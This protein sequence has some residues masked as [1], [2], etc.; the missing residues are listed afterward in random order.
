MSHYFHLLISLILLF[1]LSTLTVAKSSTQLSFDPPKI[2]SSGTAGYAINFRSSK[3]PGYATIARSKT[4]ED[5]FSR[6]LREL[7]VSMWIKTSFVTSG[8]QTTTL[9]DN[10][11]S[12]KQFRLSLIHSE[13]KNTTDV[14]FRLGSRTGTVWDVIWSPNVSVDSLTWTHLAISWRNGTLSMYKDGVLAAEH[15]TPKPLE[16]YPG[17]TDLLVAASPTEQYVATGEVTQPYIGAIDDIQIWHVGQSR[18]N[19]EG[20]RAY[21]RYPNN[22]AI[23]I[24]GYWH[25]D[26]GKGLR[27]VNNIDG[28]YSHLVL[29]PHSVL[30]S[31]AAAAMEAATATA[32]ASSSLQWIVSQA[33]VGDQIEQLEDMDTLIVLN[34][35]DNKVGRDLE[36]IITV[37]PTKGTLWEYNISSITNNGS[38]SIRGTQIKQVPHLLLPTSISKSKVVYAPAINS[39]SSVLDKYGKAANTYTQFS[40]RVKTASTESLSTSLYSSIQSVIRIFVDPVDDLPQFVHPPTVALQFAD[41]GIEDPDA[42]EREGGE[43]MGVTLSITDTKD[44]DVLVPHYSK[45]I[46]AEAAAAAAAV[47]VLP[48]SFSSDSRISLGSTDAL[49]F[50]GPLGY[51]DGKN[52]VGSSKFSGSLSNVNHAIN[53]FTLI[54]PTLFGGTVSLEVEDQGAQGRGG[55]LATAHQVGVQL[56]S[57]SIPVISEMYPV[58][59]P[60]LG[61]N[62]VLLK[63][64]NF[65]L[66]GSHVCVFGTTRANATLLPSSQLKCP[67]PPSVGGR[68]GL[69]SLLVINEAGFSSNTLQFLYE[70]SPTLIRIKPDAGPI[71]GG[72]VVLLLGEGFIH[73]KHLTCKIGEQHV[74]AQFVSNRIIKCVTPSSLIGSTAINVA[75]ANNGV[76]FGS[77]AQFTYS[78]PMSV[79][80]VS[81]QRGPSDGHT[82]VNVQ[83]IHFQNSSLLTCRFGTNVVLAIYKSPTSIHCVVPSAKSH[84]S[85]PLP[86]AVLVGVANNGYDFMDSSIVTYTYVSPIS[87]SHI[88]P[89]TGPVEG[90]TAIFIYG[91]NFLS[92]SKLQ[93]RFGS[94]TVDGGQMVPSTFFSTRM[95]RCIAPIHAR[96][97]VVVEITTNNVDFTNNDVEF[98]YQVQAAVTSISPSFGPITGGTRV[99]LTGT[100]FPRTN[101]LQCRFGERGILVPAIW[102]APTVVECIVPMVTTVQSVLVQLT[103]NTVDFTTPSDDILFSYIPPVR[104]LDIS[105]SQGP[106]RGG[107]VVTVRGSG[108]VSN[109]PTISQLYKCSFGLNIVRAI[110]IN[111]T[112]IRCTVPSISSSDLSVTVKVSTNGVQ[113]TDENM[114]F[115]Y[116]NSIQLTNIAP[117]A[118]PESGGT[119]ITVHGSGFLDST[120]L[121]CLFNSNVRVHATFI[122]SQKISCISPPAT[123]TTKRFGVT[124]TV[125]NNG[126]DIS[127]AGALQYLYHGRPTVSSISPAYGLCNQ[128]NSTTVLTVHGS[129]F[130][131]TEELSCRVG[132]VQAVK[133]QF[134]SSTVLFCTIQFL[135]AGSHQVLVSNNKVDYSTSIIASNDADDKDETQF[136]SI[137]SFSIVSM[138]PTNGSLT[139]GTDIFFRLNA[140]IAIEVIQ[141]SSI[142]SH[143][144]FGVQ[145]VTAVWENS[146]FMKCTTPAVSSPNSF[147]VDISVN[148]QDLIATNTKNINTLM[149]TYTAIPKLHRLTPKV[150]PAIGGTSIYLTGSTFDPKTDYFC[151]FGS[152]ILSTVVEAHFSSP[153]LIRCV[154]PPTNVAGPVELFLSVN[155]I[156]FMSTGMTFF[157]GQSLDLGFLTPVRGPVR[158]G[159]EIMVTGTQFPAGEDLFCNFIDERDNSTT[160]VAKATWVSRST[161]LCLTP[162]VTEPHT[163]SV[164]VMN[165]NT[166]FTDSSLRFNYHLGSEVSSIFPSQ[167]STLGGSAVIITGEN[168]LNEGNCWCKFG[169]TST[170]IVPAVF[171]SSSSIECVTPAQIKSGS[172]CVEVSNNNVDFS[173]NCIPFQFTKAARIIEMYPKHGPKSGNTHITI[174][175]KHFRAGHMQCRFGA[176]KTKAIESASNDTIVCVS[177]SSS[178]QNYV[179]LEVSNNDGIDFSQNGLQFMFVETPVINYVYPQRGPET[180][181]TTLMIGGLNFYN[182]VDMTCLF[183]DDDGIEKGNVVKSPATWVSSSSLTCVSPPYRPSTVRVAI[184]SNGQQHTDSNIPYEYHSRI[185]I[186]QLLPTRGSLHG[187][188]V[189]MLSGSGFINSTR[190]SCRFGS[191]IVLATFL[192]NTAIVCASPAASIEKHVNV[193]ASNNGVDFSSVGKQFMFAL[194]AIVKGLSPR[195]GPSEGGT[196]ILVSGSNF[197]DID[198]LKCHFT[199]DKHTQ[200]TVASFI[201]QNAVMCYSPKY[202]NSGPVEVFVS[203]D[204]V[205]KTAHHSVTFMYYENNIVTSLSPSRGSETG[206]TPVVILGTNFLASDTL[207]CKFGD[208]V[209]TVASW[210]SSVA[211]RCSSPSNSPGSVVAVEVSNNGI[212]FTTNHVMYTYVETLSVSSILPDSGPMHGGTRIQVFGS[213]LMQSTAG[214]CKFGSASQSTRAVHVSNN[215]IECVTPAQIKSGSV[216]VEV[217]NN[218]VDFSHNCIPFQFTKAA[219]IIEM[220]PKHG[221]KSGNTHITIKGKHFRAGHMQC[222][223]G[224]IKTKAIESASNDTIVCVSPSSSL[225]NYVTL[226]VSNNDGIDFSQNGLQFMFV[227]TPVINYV[228]PQ[229]GP[230]TGSTTLMIGGLNFYNSVD[231]TCLFFDDD[232]IEK[233]N[234]VKSPA[235]WVSSS[236]LTC[237]SPPYRPSTVR[238][239]ISSNG[240]QHTDSNIPY[241]Y[242]SRIGITQLLPTRGSL[243]GGT[244]VMLSGSGFINSTR[245][246]CRFGSTIVLATFVSNASIHFT[247]P[248][249]ERGHVNVEVSNNGI[250]F[251]NN[252]I[253]YEFI[254][255]SKI[256]Q[257]IPRSG[258]A[259]G[260]TQITFDVTNLAASKS[261]SIVSCRFNNEIIIEAH[262]VEMSSTFSTTSITSSETNMSQITCM[263]PV[264]SVGLVALEILFDGLNIAEQSLSNFLYYKIPIV[265]EILPKFVHESGGTSISVHGSNFKNTDKIFCRFGEGD[266]KRKHIVRATWLAAGLL[267]CVAPAKQPGPAFVDV[268]FNGVDY[269]ND[270]VSIIYVTKTTITSMKPIQGNAGGGTIIEIIGTGFVS[271]SSNLSPVCIFGGIQIVSHIYNETHMK[272][273]APA[274]PTSMSSSFPLSTQRL[275]AFNIMNSDFLQSTTGSESNSIDVQN[276]QSSLATT[277][278]VTSDWNF[279]YIPETLILSVNPS[280]GPINKSILITINAVGIPLKGNENGNAILCVFQTV[281]MNEY[282][283]PIHMPSLTATSV[284]CMTPV[285]NGIG[286]ISVRLIIENSDKINE[287]DEKDENNSSRLLNEISDI[288]ESSVQF[289]V[290][291]NLQIIDTVPLIGSENGNTNILI[292][293]DRG[294]GPISFTPLICIFGKSN[295]YITHAT[296]VGNSQVECVSPEHA[297][298]TVELTVA[299]IF[300]STDTID[301]MNATN[302]IKVVLINNEATLIGT[303][304]NAIQFTY[305]ETITIVSILPTK[306]NG[307]GGS[308]INILGTNFLN[309][310]LLACRFGMSASQVVPATWYNSSSLSCITPHMDLTSFT[311]G[312]DISSININIYIT[313]N[314]VEWFKSHSNNPTNDQII[315]THQSDAFE[316][317]SL[318]PSRGPSIG[319][320]VIQ[321]T[322]SNYKKEQHGD[323]NHNIDGNGDGSSKDGEDGEDGEENKYLACR[324][325]QN[326]IVPA[327][328]LSETSLQCITPTAP[329]ASVTIDSMYRMAVEVTFN[330]IDYTNDGLIFTYYQNPEILSI[331]PK[332]GSE[333]GGQKIM[334]NGVGFP[335]SS[336]LFNVLC[337]FGE[338]DTTAIHE[339]RTKKT[340]AVWISS[341]MLSCVTPVHSPGHIS[342]SLSFNNGVDYTDGSSIFE[343]QTAARISYIYPT[344]GSVYGGTTIYM[345]G[346][347]FEQNNTITST[348]NGGIGVEA[349]AS[350]AGTAG[351]AGTAIT[352]SG[353]SNKLFCQFGTS[354]TSVYILNETHMSCRTSPQLKIGSLLLNVLTQDGDLLWTEKDLMFK[355][356]PHLVVSH[357]NPTWGT[358]NGDTNIILRGNGMQNT[359]FTFC[360]FRQLGSSNDN[361]GN[362]EIEFKTQAMFLTKWRMSCKT[363]RVH[364]PGRYAVEVSNNGIEYSTNGKQYNIV[365]FFP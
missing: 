165:L 118:G 343:Y 218:N 292:H 167:G 50:A 327:I 263:S 328:K 5:S 134:L 193:H 346:V 112:H 147:L 85:K 69:I 217:S 329:L 57:G 357:I 199:S 246:S 339:K 277:Q 278:L 358:V 222:R 68:I 275:V 24:A 8:Q 16:L 210:I 241:E 40:F 312:Q 323:N 205:V 344:S 48:S 214:F 88:S 139:G 113:F 173:H 320:T 42:W 150:G 179:T 334:I 41:Y 98:E 131:N 309:T 29:H 270:Q 338:D 169:N 285:F 249:Y 325:N 13:S 74:P 73:T 72:T 149:F 251:S 45:Q 271:S 95:V 94:N 166:E 254:R 224:A 30:V 27:S 296:Y 6:G 301:T 221:P 245:L 306:I 240:Q 182:S 340:A 228:Y 162:V 109:D 269:T 176:I 336:N 92:S 145:T 158:G 47:D 317:I 51:G 136:L 70:M 104:V 120:H 298:G 174:K 171:I 202:S 226:E 54:T 238:V 331:A 101:K 129:G 117:K 111:S 170:S 349:A 2:P 335:K 61:G 7:T 186:T 64:T 4:Q 91:H 12:K 160:T 237:V 32:A 333:M 190:L 265:N 122:N 192:N 77:T 44:K 19:L 286:I 318:I 364:V 363:P 365:L 37:L 34:A 105:P 273:K 168:F 233:G 305:Y 267:E 197:Q 62:T 142:L 163:V 189:V 133:T 319:G 208:N 56:R 207:M 79:I 46:S 135:Q 124:I 52:D 351:A 326:I 159:T 293:V 211:I 225:Q 337:K 287:K 354:I 53:D 181:S 308:R 255:V 244:V 272:C 361:D 248:P 123:T 256:I 314:G 274:S 324:F 99:V 39:H 198:A 322:M 355:Y 291:G 362:Q 213:G 311:N 60:P 352:T 103:S 90:G 1:T 264:G 295:T 144:Q 281:G 242:H 65:H 300:T 137:P 294:Y 330:G 310:S 184:S 303:Q 3:S 152:G 67:I 284:Q 175:G 316:L 15:A 164:H 299:T 276:Q 203:K 78:E 126:A 178:L 49:D 155:N 236:S 216:C 313:T 201:S 191:T 289:T 307:R 82:L 180:G 146:S 119:A 55:S 200:S 341:R 321:I 231:M 14:Q 229:R 227:E 75:V 26:E 290:H 353:S 260:G 80:E 140:S 220:Y 283:V 66:G 196:K 97:R 280:F 359:S 107:T 304:S 58:S 138:Y 116:Y 63:G 115:V 114:L 76:H 17:T 258:P 157:Y 219:R 20:T 187:G 108:F 153:S 194:E 22:H 148:G 87:I 183:F 71:V 130:T 93:C 257:M 10:S 11:I 100:G 262:F 43:F 21:H 151:K 212:D 59:A 243:H 128:V 86:Y 83:G 360:L 84:G 185:G 297:P 279:T 18:F 161:L 252:N 356:L 188:T 177:P 38:S 268:S 28:W 143:C 342:I 127:A 132:N 141:S 282:K 232:G 81:P 106:S 35:T 350:A 36:Y 239:A 215:S 154:T 302:N 23:G 315:V 172:V 266:S 348:A 96:G 250:D 89:K 247:T 206:N 234:V 121:H 223:F 125:S 209:P 261:K 235:T 332:I 288:S 102:V 347:N 253:H 33:I 9:L 204:S 25:L 156:D 110:M 31:S 345:I 230:E 259:S 195:I